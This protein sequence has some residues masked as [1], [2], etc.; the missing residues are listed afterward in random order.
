MAES[1]RWVGVGVGALIVRDDEVLLL[2]R[3][4]V[5]GDGTWST[6]GGHVDFGETL[7]RCAAREVEEETGLVVGEVRFLAVT[8]D[9]MPADDR[10]YVTVWMRCDHAGGEPRVAAAHEMSEVRWFP[11]DALPEPLFTSLANLTSGAAHGLAH[12]W[13][14]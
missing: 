12:G 3:R 11:V 6:P 1:G 10:H 4:N 9:V 7:E 5:H 2:R 13:L 8:N 14:E